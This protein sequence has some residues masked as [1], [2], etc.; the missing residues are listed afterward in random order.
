[1]LLPWCRRNNSID[2]GANKLHESIENDNS[3]TKKDVYLFYII[4]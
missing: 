4:F 2:Y 1:M 3:V